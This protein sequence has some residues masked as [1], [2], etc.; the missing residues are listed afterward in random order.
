[1]EL[2]QTIVHAKSPQ[3]KSDEYQFLKANSQPELNME[4]TQAT[5]SQQVLQLHNFCR[6]KL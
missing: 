6:Q 1:M 2:E 3:Q 5:Y 4:S